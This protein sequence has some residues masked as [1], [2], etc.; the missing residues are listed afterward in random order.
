[1]PQS[2][3]NRPIPLRDVLRVDALPP[4]KDASV[5]RSAVSTGTEQ[6]KVSADAIPVGYPF[7]K[8][9]SLRN[10]GIAYG[11]VIVERYACF[12]KGGFRL[13]PPSLS[14][15]TRTSRTYPPIATPLDLSQLQPGDSI[16][17]EAE[18]P[19]EP[20]A[21]TAGAQPRRK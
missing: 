5:P 3:L 1:M 21:V 10:D 13:E 19:A 17:P 7:T 4:K 2:K 20:G 16:S 6:I 14:I 9:V 18:A 12:V 8:S 11:E 15:R